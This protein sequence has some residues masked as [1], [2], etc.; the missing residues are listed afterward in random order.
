MRQSIFVV[1]DVDGENSVGLVF[2][3]A[4][5]AARDAAEGILDR[6]FEMMADESKPLC[7]LLTCA[8]ATAA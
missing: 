2:G 3:L 4:L 1:L 8:I 6:G 7:Y 5:M